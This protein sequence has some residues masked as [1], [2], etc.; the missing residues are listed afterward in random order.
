MSLLDS[1]FGG[2]DDTQT[3]TTSIDPQ[4]KAAFLGNVD[5]A[6]EVA[7]Q[8]GQQQFAGFDPLYQQGEALAQATVG[9]PGQQMVGQAGQ[10][11]QAL[12]A[13]A[14]QQVGADPAAIQAYMNPYTQQVVDTTLADL[15]KQRL[16]MMN[17]IGAQATQARAFGG[18]R[19][20]IAEAAANQ[21][22]AQT[23]ANTIANLRSQG[24]SQALSA[25]Q[26]AALANQ[27]AG[28]QGAQLRGQIA[29][30]LGNIGQTQQAL[31]YQGAQN[32]MQLGTAR[33]QL[34]QQQMDAARGL[35]MERLGIMSGALGVQPANI[36]GTTSQPVYSNTGASVLGSA[37]AGYQLAGT[38]GVSPTTGAFGGGLLGLL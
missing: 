24:Y 14:P 2:D 22:I 38:L 5:Y 32:L 18:S 7:N 31:G 25:A 8:L 34:A 36:G 29:G 26:Q 1:L 9:G 37:L 33:Q 28:L 16:G 27:T 15:E 3:V 23:A 11:T 30:Q 20:G 12:G 19:H 21:Q 17:Q 35:G 4:M 6:R 10:L 13:Y